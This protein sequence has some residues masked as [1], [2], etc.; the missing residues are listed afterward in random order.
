MLINHTILASQC[1]DSFPEINIPQ[2]V[3][4]SFFGLESVKGVC[5]PNI[6]NAFCLIS[7]VLSEINNKT[8]PLVKQLI[9]ENIKDGEWAYN[10]LD[11]TIQDLLDNIQVTYVTIEDGIHHA[12]V[13]TRNI[14]K[15]SATSDEEKIYDYEPVINPEGK[16]L[17]MYLPSS[18][19][20][21]LWI[22]RIC[23]C[24]NPELVLQK[25]LMHELIHAILDVSPRILNINQNTGTLACKV[26][27]YEYDRDSE[28][29]LDNS[30]VL[31]V[32][33]QI[34]N[35]VYQKI[36]DFIEGQP[37]PYK[38]AINLYKKGMDHIMRVL[39]KHQ[40]SKVS[41]KEDSKLIVPKLLYSFDYTLTDEEYQADNEP[42]IYQ[43]FKSWC[44][45]IECVIDFEKKISINAL[46]VKY[47]STYEMSKYEIILKSI[48]SHDDDQ[49]YISINR[50]YLY[51]KVN[52]TLYKNY[53]IFD[54]TITDNP[55]LKGLLEFL[56]ITINPY[57]EHPIVK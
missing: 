19:S 15:Y 5:A 2:V 32:Y 55:F 26:L 11:N 34:A 56:I 18:G 8:N 46:C 45:E 14:F 23:V 38:E 13:K 48:N 7:S 9:T 36:R 29:T 37:T 51:S 10:P 52:N 54:K 31:Y 47:V 24:E 17:G 41:P 50:V 35:E 25:V 42:S 49:T 6:S 44:N 53:R 30:L 39:L 4:Q 43:K 3:N 12:K 16:L 22:D 20:I 57:S 1:V 40:L 28:E 33:N 21:M 27:C